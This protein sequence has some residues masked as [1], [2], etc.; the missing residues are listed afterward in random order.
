MI[1]PVLPT[2]IED[3]VGIKRHPTRHY[4]R[5]ISDRRKVYILHSQTCIINSRDL[6]YCP[7][8]LALDLGIDDVFDQWRDV[9]DR[10]V[11]VGIQNGYLVPDPITQ[12]VDGEF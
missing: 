4:A 2:I 1:K 6:R 12:E 8:S 3:I 7:F 9:Q 11:I 5:A 10:P